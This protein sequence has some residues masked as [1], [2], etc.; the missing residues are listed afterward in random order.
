M[1][2]RHGGPRPKGSLVHE[3]PRALFVGLGRSGKIWLRLH[4]SRFAV[5]WNRCLGGMEDFLIV[6]LCL[7]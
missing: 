6:E 7:A 2:P 5:R 4:R 1:T 3:P